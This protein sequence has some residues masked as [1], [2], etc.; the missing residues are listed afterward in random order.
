MNTCHSGK[1]LLLWAITSMV[2]GCSSAKRP[3]EAELKK[4]VISTRAFRHEVHLQAALELTCASCHVP[5]DGWDTGRPGSNDHAPCDSCHR[6]KFATQEGGEFCEVCH[7]KTDPR[8][9]GESPL[10]PFPRHL[11]A[12]QLVSEFDHQGH[13]TRGG[14][15]GQALTCR[16]C[17][18]IQGAF[19][20]FPTHADCAPCH[21]EKHPP[22]LGECERCHSRES[23]GTA[24]RFVT[25]DIRFTHE[26]HL[27]ELSGEA[28]PCLA[29]HQAVP[30][31]TKASD[32]NLPRMRECATCHANPRKV[33]P[34]KRI[35]Q[36]G[37]CHLRNV[38]SKD[39]PVNHSTVDLPE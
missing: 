28:L 13:L 2:A 18:D 37:L 1:R 7:E 20:S 27:T 25:N 29:C 19:A 6:E 11:M 32:L 31:S 16:S 4:P 5:K 30:K 9:P 33:P 10:H 22:R 38:R 15:S 12:A 8:R 39:I 23:T 14:E 35:D 24:R 17:H 36:C 34:E 26:R 3:V 21:A